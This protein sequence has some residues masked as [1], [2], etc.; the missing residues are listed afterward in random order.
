LLLVAA[1][2]VVAF[3]RLEQPRGLP[4]FVQLGLGLV[5]V[6]VGTYAVSSDAHPFYWLVVLLPLVAA[7][8][9]PGRPSQSG[10]GSFMLAFLAATALTHVVFFGEDRYHLVVTPIL[11]L[12]AAAA[13]RPQGTTATPSVSASAR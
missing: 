2:A 9:L 13:L 4:F 5:L 10:A 6:S 12:L 3:P 1:F 8:N 11:C 7:F